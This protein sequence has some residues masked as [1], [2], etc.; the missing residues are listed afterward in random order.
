MRSQL[1]GWVGAWRGRLRALRRE[2]YVLFF[3]CQDERTP[4]YAKLTAAVVVAYAFS[5]IDL[6][7]E[8]IPVIGLL[9]DVVL[10]PLGVVLVRWMVP[11]QVLSDCR[12]RA[13]CAINNGKPVSWTAGVVIVGLWVVA[14]YF[15]YRLVQDWFWRSVHF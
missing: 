14:A 6:I 8:F 3:A 7:P 15:T 12:V 10:I 4:W 5:P 11:D 9:D 2:T 13:E 1:A